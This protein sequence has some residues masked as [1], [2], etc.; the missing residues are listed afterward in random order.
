MSALTSKK[1][2]SMNHCIER[3]ADIWRESENSRVHSQ[4]ERYNILLPKYRRYSFCLIKIHTGF[5]ES[6]LAHITNLV[7]HESR[8]AYVTEV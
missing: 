4:R 5:L 1:Q 6:D 7:H 8:S 3:T 2:E